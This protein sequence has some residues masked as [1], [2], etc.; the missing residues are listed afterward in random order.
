MIII[1]GYDPG[2]TRGYEFDSWS[3]RYQVP[4]TWMGD[5]LRIG[6]PFS[7]DNQQQGPDLLSFRGR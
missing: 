7:V 5:C 6:K 3:G 2:R 4:T 1:N